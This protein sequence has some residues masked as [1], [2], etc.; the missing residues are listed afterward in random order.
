MKY[1]PQKESVCVCLCVCVCVYL[2]FC[3]QP[4]WLDWAGVVYPRLPP[5]WRPLQCRGQYICVHN[6]PANSSIRLKRLPMRT[7]KRPLRGDPNTEGL[8]SVPQK[9]LELWSTPSPPSLP[10]T[11]FCV[12]TPTVR[13]IG[14]VTNDLVC[15]QCA[16]CKHKRTW[17]PNRGK[18]HVN[19]WAQEKINTAVCTEKFG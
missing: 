6:R 18:R 4:V 16:P 2:S 11:Q 19:I 3:P 15:A 10:S 1:W 13:L 17:I 8:W 9:H 12:L 5:Q 14:P 7:I